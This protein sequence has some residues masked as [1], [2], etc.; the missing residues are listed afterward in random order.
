MNSEKLLEFLKVYRDEDFQFILISQ[1][2]TTVGRYKNVMSI[3]ALLPPPNVIASWIN[4]GEKSK[5]KEKYFNYLRNPEVESLVT[6]MI[7]AVIDGMNIVIIC[8]KSEDDMKYLKMLAEFIEEEYKL[9]VLTFKEFDKNPA[10]TVEIKNKEEVEAI[11][12]DK[13]E[14]IR[15]EIGG[16]SITP[17]INQDKI[18]KKLKELDK[19]ELIKYC[20][21]HGIK[22]D[23]DTSKKKIIKKILNKI[24]S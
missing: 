7:K 6:I 19:Y 22:A 23:E 20:H 17:N 15:E 9:K 12:I 14:Y 8:S 11:L 18:E 24:K 16:S 10:L 2:I 3:K 4:D 13:L 21:H 1:D 5:Y